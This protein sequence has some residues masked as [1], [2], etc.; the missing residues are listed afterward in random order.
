MPCKEVRVFCLLALPRV[1]RG[2]HH[3]E[4]CSPGGSFYVDDTASSFNRRGASVL[5]R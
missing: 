1:I 4:P 3:F 2:R 5:S